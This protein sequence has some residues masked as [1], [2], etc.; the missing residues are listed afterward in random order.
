[1]DWIQMETKS[2]ARVSTQWVE[3]QS[4]ERRTDN[5]YM[6]IAPPSDWDSTMIQRLMTRER[7]RANPFRVPL[8]IGSL[9]AC[10]TVFALGLR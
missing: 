6:Y 7:N 4:L 9:V 10:I 8:L 5:S 1:M 3:G 2:K